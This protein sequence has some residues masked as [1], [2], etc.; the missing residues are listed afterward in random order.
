MKRRIEVEHRARYDKKEHS[1]L[2]SFLRRQARSL[3]HDDQEVFF[4]ASP[5][6]LYKAVKNISHN[7]AKLVLKKNRIEKASSFDEIEIAISPQDIKK[8]NE[9]LKTIPQVKPYHDSI[10]REN[11]RW[12]G[13]E[14]AL[15]YGQTWG[16]HAELEILIS[17]RRDLA[18]ANKKIQQVANALGIKLMTTNNVAKF[19]RIANH[20]KR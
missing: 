15:K 8:A 5:S 16:Y 17:T 3:G 6:V 7:T 4:Y 18:R 12:R 1:R 9:L 10:Q 11:Y 20:K 14:V 2:R 19:L 13:V